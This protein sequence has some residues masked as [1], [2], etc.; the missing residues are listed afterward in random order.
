FVFAGLPE[1]ARE[2]QVENL[3]Q[4]KK[5]IIKD[6]RCATKDIDIRLSLDTRFLHAKVF[7]F[8]SKNKLPE[9]LIGSANFSNSAF[10]QN[11]EAMV[12]I[13]GK[14]PGLRDYIEHVLDTST[15]IEGLKPET[16]A[17]TWRDFLRNAYV[18][19]RPSGTVSFAIDPFWDDEFHEIA[20]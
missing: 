12:A 4:L 10:A 13:K 17:R 1:V 20:G 15:S 14:H 18:Y 3:T 11:D 8:R 16:E 19:Y 5:D 9:Y 7:R 2:E 6:T